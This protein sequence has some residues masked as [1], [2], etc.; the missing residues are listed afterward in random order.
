MRMKASVCLLLLASS[1]E[2]SV[3]NYDEQK[4]GV[5]SPVAH[6]EE[7]DDVDLPYTPTEMKTKTDGTY[8]VTL[9][10]GT[11]ISVTLTAAVA[12]GVFDDCNVPGP[13]FAGSGNYPWLLD[14]R[15]PDDSQGGLRVRIDW[16][17]VDL[18]GWGPADSEAYGRCREFY[19]GAAGQPFLDGRQYTFW[20]A[21]ASPKMPFVY[22]DDRDSSWY[23][24]SNGEATDIWADASQFYVEAS[25]MPPIGAAYVDVSNCLKMVK[26]L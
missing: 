14:C 5:V 25:D 20:S 17:R 9:P 26:Q 1:C 11:R 19:L 12:D 10:D 7:V 16:D 6:I 4:C 13:T 18:P 15:N 23:M 2:G 8:I 21:D 22:F 24:C 3:D